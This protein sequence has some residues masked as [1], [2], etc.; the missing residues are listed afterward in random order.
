MEHGRAAE[1]QRRPAEGRDPSMT[2]GLGRQHGLEVE[3]RLS[4]SDNGVCCGHGTPFS[5]LVQRLRTGIWP[6][7]GKVR[8]MIRCA[9]KT[10]GRQAD[11]WGKRSVA[12]TSP[13]CIDQTREHR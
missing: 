6:K 5:N 9:V 1:R 3:R 2:V 10:M 4:G 12:A 13:G 11:S 7:R 8:Q